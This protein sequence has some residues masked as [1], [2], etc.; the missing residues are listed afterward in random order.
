MVSEQIFVIGPKQELHEVE[1]VESGTLDIEPNDLEEMLQAR[2]P[3]SNHPRKASYLSYRACGFSVREAC[4]MA[5]VSQ[6]TVNKWRRDDPEFKELEGPK[7]SF[8]QHSLSRDILRMEFMRNFRLA[9]RRDFKILYR[10]AYNFNSLTETEYDYL[11]VIRRL[12]GPSD[13]LAL[14]KAL[15]PEHG[16]RAPIHVEKGVFIVDG[17]EV[18]SEEAKRVAARRLLDRFT[19][20][21]KFAQEQGLIE[22]SV[23]ESDGS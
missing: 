10:A 4:T 15:E 2:L 3:A 19:S 22:T 13:L 18:E 21:G 17:R 23:V 8:L 11:K 1:Q 7:L 9:L 20:N 6:H 12:Y 16:E 5:E 14:E